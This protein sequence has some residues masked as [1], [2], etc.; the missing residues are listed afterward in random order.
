MRDLFQMLALVLL[1]QNRV[2]LSRANNPWYHPVARC[3]GHSR[4]SRASVFS[5]APHSLIDVGARPHLC[6]DDQNLSTPLQKRLS[7][8]QAGLARL[9]PSGPSLARLMPS[10]PSLGLETNRRNFSKYFA[11]YFHHVVNQQHV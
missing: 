5:N 3:T 10:G 7:R 2:S 6:L 1:S 8:T 4:I 11:S 9:M